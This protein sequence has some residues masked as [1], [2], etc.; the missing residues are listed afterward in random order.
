MFQELEGVLAPGGVSSDAGRSKHGRVVL[1]ALTAGASDSA[2]QPGLAIKYVAAGLEVYCYGGRTY[3]VSAG[4]FLL[5]PEGNAGEVAIGRS[6]DQALGLCVYLPAGGPSVAHPFET[7]IGFAAA[8]SDLGRMMAGVHMRMASATQGR[9]ELATQLLHRVSRNLE[10]FLEETA[11]ALTSLS[12]LKPSTRHELLRR[13][14]LARGYL[15]DVT[16]RPVELIELSRVAGISRFQLL[17][18]FRDCFGAPPASYHR[19]LRLSL[20]RDAI[21]TE[22]LPCAEAAHRFG[23]ADGS[24]F[25]HAYRRAFGEPPG[26]HALNH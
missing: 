11:R 14:N 6:K 9:P 2:G 8:C 15:H 24:S 3:A 17:R 26:H 19:S 21:R 23:F 25:S 4:Q 10:P 12:A 22:R 5:V 1:S 16:D 13:L 7:P 18:D 20:A